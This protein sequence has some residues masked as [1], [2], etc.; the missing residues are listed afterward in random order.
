MIA[1]MMTGDKAAE[2]MAVRNAGAGTAFGQGMGLRGIQDGSEP[3]TSGRKK[4]QH[5]SLIL[6]QDER[7]RRA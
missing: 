3:E 7:W 5:E 4:L 6:A 2:G 1:D